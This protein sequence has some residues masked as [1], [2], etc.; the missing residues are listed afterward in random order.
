MAVV[1]GDFNFSFDCGNGQNLVENDTNDFTFEPI[2][3]GQPGGGEWWCCKIENSAYH[4]QT[5]DFTI[6]GLD[7]YN[8]NHETY[9]PQ[10]VYSYDG[11]NWNRVTGA[12]YDDG[13][14]TLTFQ[15][16]FTATGT[17]VIVCI[18]PPFTYTA[19]A[20]W[21]AGLSSSD[22]VVENL[23]AIDSRNMYLLTLTRDM[24][25]QRFKKSV[26]IFAGVH[27]TEV[28]SMWVVKGLV[29]FLLDGTD[30]ADRLLKEFTWKIFPMVNPDGVYSGTGYENKEGYNIF[31]DFVNQNTTNVGYI[32]DALDDWGLVPDMWL[33]CHCAIGSSYEYFKLHINDAV[34]GGTDF[35]I[36]KNQ[37]ALAGCL[38]N[39]TIMDATSDIDRS[40][41]GSLANY[42]FNV[43]GCLHG[44]VLEFCNLDPANTITRSIE[45]GK[46]VAMAV[47]DYFMGKG[48]AANHFNSMRR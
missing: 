26:W 12:T 34:E 45:Q 24:A 29:D 3:T 32:I 2:V 23:G 18:N 22:L 4:N 16:T 13:T 30:A 21:V 9:P 17:E 1:A 15:I 27:P 10:P 38:M 28:W 41:N 33:D 47:H 36:R 44:T 25:R 37:L 35:A 6:E 7:R 8:S 40:G 11:D 20:A 46:H 5:V 39:R 42:F 14:N 48:K 43:E 31:Q 19:M